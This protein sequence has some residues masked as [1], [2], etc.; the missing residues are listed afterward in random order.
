MCCVVWCV[1]Y[2]IYICLCMKS[3]TCEKEQSLLLMFCRQVRLPK[4]KL[5][6]FVVIVFQLCPTFH[7]VF[8]L[9]ASFFRFYTLTYTLTLTLTEAQCTTLVV[10]CNSDM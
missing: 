3:Q 8:M 10:A 2:Y 9:I 4:R 5:V 7:S 6:N 1:L